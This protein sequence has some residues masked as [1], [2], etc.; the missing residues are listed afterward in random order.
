MLINSYNVNMESASS[1]VQKH[2]STMCSTLI[3]QNLEGSENNNNIKLSTNSINY[4]KTIVFNSEENMSVEDR[5]K[6][7]LIEILLSKLNGKDKKIDLYP[8]G[9]MDKNKKYDFN[10]HFNNQNISI[11]AFA[12]SYES[13]ET[14]YQKSSVHFSTN[15]QINTSS[16]SFNIDLNLYFSQEFYEQ[17]KTKIEIAGVT[18]QDPLIINFDDKNINSFDNISKKITFEFDL[19]NNG[20]KEKIPLLKDGSGFLALDKNNNGTID[21]GNELFGPNTGY[22]FKELAKY[23]EDGNNWIDEAD[24]IFNSLKIWEINEEGENNLITLSQAGVGAIY[25]SS[26]ATGFNYS[27]AYGEQTASLKESS[28]FLK[29]NGEA[30][31]ITSIDLVV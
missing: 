2:E 23:D 5:M 26:I 9:N 14:Y 12:A 17:H 28:I 8:F 24:S 19:D 7:L 3:T 30:G 4:T 22:G 27:K 20:T 11:N 25:L 16:G 10:P 6:K 15:A 18:F 31:L 29:E 13:V 21:N 1:F